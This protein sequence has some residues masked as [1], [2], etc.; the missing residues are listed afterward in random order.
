MTPAAAEHSDAG[1]LHCDA[2]A[3]TSISRAEAPDLRRYSCEL[4]MPALPPVDIEPQM[5]FLFTCSLGEANS[6]ETCFQSQSSSSATSCARPVRLP[7][8][9]SERA[10]RMTMRSSGWITSQ[11]V[12]STGAAAPACASAG[13][14][15]ENSSASPPPTA[16]EAWRN[17]LRLVMAASSGFRAGER[18][19]RLAHATIGPAAAKVPDGRVDLRV[20]GL[21]MLLEQRRHRHD[22]SGLAV[23]ALRHLVLDPRLLHAMQ[24]ALAQPLDGEHVLPRGGR[25]GRDARPHRRPIHVHGARTALG[26]AAPVL[27][28]GELQLVA[29]HPEQGHLALD[30]DF[31][32]ATVHRQL[33]GNLPG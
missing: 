27:R 9:I 22:H 23:A 30:V 31:V 29:Q 28:A 11:W 17:C 3:A 32:G 18:V 1:T 8:P 10:M 15:R 4:R 6:V 20:G 13:A 24:S 19:D 12:T 21:G 25:R 7:C 2:A 5:R 26:H 33:H 16:A 14:V